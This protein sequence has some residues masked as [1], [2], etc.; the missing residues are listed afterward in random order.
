MYP[1]PI[2]R[3][4]LMRQTTLEHDAADLAAGSSPPTD[5]ATWPDGHPDGRSVAIPWNLAGVCG[6]PEPAGRRLVVSGLISDAQAR[7]IA[8]EWHSGQ[9]SALRSLAT[10]GLLDRDQMRAELAD[11]LQRLDR[12]PDDNCYEDPDYLRTELRALDKDV[13]Q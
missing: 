3:H 5:Q 4:A 2:R 9:S 10:T 12:N 6:W 11:E 7:R 8:A 1:E 13:A